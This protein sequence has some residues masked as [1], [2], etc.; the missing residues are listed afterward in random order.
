M[1]ASGGEEG[2]RLFFLFIHLV[3]V[4]LGG[5]GVVLTA[6]APAVRKG[7]VAGCCNVMAN[8]AVVNTGLFHSF[9]TDVHSVMNNHS[10][11]CRRMLQRT[12][13]ATLQRV[14]SRTTLLKT[15]TM[16]K[17]SLSCRA[18]KSDNDVLVMATDNATI[19]VRS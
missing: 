6:A 1:I 12:G 7:H 19:E 17:I 14:R 4:W 3:G 11:S 18:I 2:L 5:E 9:F 10:N 15:G 16:I 8:R 13:S